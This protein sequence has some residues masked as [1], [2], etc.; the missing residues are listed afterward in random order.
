M[1]GFGGVA[2]RLREMTNMMLPFLLLLLFLAQSPLFV[3]SD[4]TGIWGTL[5]ALLGISSNPGVS[6]DTRKTEIGVAQNMTTSTPFAKI[7]DT[8]DILEYMERKGRKD[9]SRPL[10]GL[11][12]WQV[13]VQF[14][15]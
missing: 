8:P 4:A 1:A 15:P 13:G 9:T 14:V 10:C 12:Q 2:D 3:S 5:S 6:L 7:L 11:N